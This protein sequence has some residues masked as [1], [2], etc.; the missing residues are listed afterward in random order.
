MSQGGSRKKVTNRLMAVGSAAVMAVYSAGYTRTR[1]AAQHFEEQSNERRAPVSSA[2]APSNELPA[3]SLTPGAEPVA[4]SAPE[5]KRSVAVPVETAAAAAPSP[6]EP[7]PKT[8][9]TPSEP[10]ITPAAP[11]SGPA[12]VEEHKVEKVEVAAIP[13]A[14]APTPPPPPPPQ[15]KATW[16]DG[17]YLG[18][19]TSRHGE[20]QAQVIVANGKIASATI[21]QCLTRYSCSVISHLPPQVIQRQSPDVDYVSG[22]TQSANALYYAVA[23]AL[24]KAK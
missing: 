9:A 11:E 20:I 17:T 1:S 5:P 4:V 12:P 15:A 23:D 24:S 2:A 10:A 8:P 13:A 3:T 7:A 21:A 16:K 18:W 19:G 6:K 14:P 22:A